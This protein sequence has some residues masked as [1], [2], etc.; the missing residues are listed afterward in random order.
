MS[1]PIHAARC[2]KRDATSVDVQLTPTPASGAQFPFSRFFGLWLLHEAATSVVY[3]GGK[4]LWRSA[5]PAGALAGALDHAE[6][7]ELTD[8]ETPDERLIRPP[9]PAERRA[10]QQRKRELV[11]RFITRVSYG[12]VRHWEPMICELDDVAGR[13]LEP[14]TRAMPRCRE[15]AEILQ[16]IFDRAPERELPTA[17]LRIEVTDARWIAHLEPGMAWD[18]YVYDS[19]AGELV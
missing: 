19:D 18:V 7:A 11:D 1:S 12:D 2:A 13:Y 6:L 10:L 5:A 9:S 16:R 8:T 4:P 3:R 17:T 14:A 15:A